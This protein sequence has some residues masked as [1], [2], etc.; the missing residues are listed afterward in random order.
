M[1]YC[2]AVTISIV[3][4]HCNPKTPPST[5]EQHQN[6]DHA[7]VTMLKSNTYSTSSAAPHPPETISIYPLA[8]AQRNVDAG[9]YYLEFDPYNILKPLLNLR[10][11]E[12]GRKARKRRMR[13]YSPLL[14]IEDA[15]R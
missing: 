8:L 7:N 6:N 11:L 12:S 14:G 9:G 5:D 4:D 2:I 1:I 15:V 10:L 13:K 3:I